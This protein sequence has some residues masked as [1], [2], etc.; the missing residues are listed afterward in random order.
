[1]KKHKIIRLK[2]ILNLVMGP[3]RG[4]NIKKNWSTDRRWQ[5]QLQLQKLSRDDYRQ[6]INMKA[7]YSHETK[8]SQHHQTIKLVTRQKIKSGDQK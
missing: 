7:A 6:Q 5:N 8:T 4:P 3:K 2:K 1:M